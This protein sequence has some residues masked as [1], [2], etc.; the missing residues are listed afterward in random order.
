M[1]EVSY[2]KDDV[3]TQNIID[4]VEKSF[5]IMLRMSEA[6]HANFVACVLEIALKHV[7][8]FRLDVS[9]VSTLCINSLQQ[10]LGILLLE[11]YLVVSEQD[12]QWH[13]QKADSRP[14][15][16]KRLKIESLTKAKTDAENNED[17]ASLM[18]LE[19]AKLYRSISDYDS[20]KAIFNKTKLSSEHTRAG[21]EHE[22]NNDYYEA[23]KCYQEALNEL[24]ADETKRTHNRLGKLEEELWE[25]SLLRCCNELV[26]WR[27]MCE[28]STQTRKLNELFTDDAYSFECLF[29]YAFR[30][31][32][33]LVLQEDIDEQRKHEDLI[34]FLKSLTG[35]TKSFVENAYAYEL[36]L[37][38]MHQGD[39]NASRYF[40]YAA[41][42][43]YLTEWSSIN[44]NII[45][46]RMSK[47][48]SLQS[49]VEL[50]E[51]LNF[52]DQLH[53]Y[54]GGGGSGSSNGFNLFAKTN[55]LIDL[56][57]DAMPNAYSDPPATWDDVITNRCIYLE[58]I[59]EKHLN[60]AMASS[61]NSDLN[62]SSVSFLSVSNAKRRK[63]ADDDDNVEEK[64]L[65]RL[66][67]KIERTKILMKIRFAQALHI[68]GNFKL[69]MSKL[70]QTKSILKSQSS[71]LCDLQIAWMHCYLNAHLSRSRTALN[72]VEE[73]LSR[74]LGA[75][76]LQEICKYDEHNEIS[77]GKELYDE[78]KI[79][80]SKFATFL[81][82]SYQTL[83]SSDTLESYLNKLKKEEKK[84]NQ[85]VDYVGTKNLSDVKEV[86]FSSFFF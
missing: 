77:I 54:N 64:K 44:K 31:K 2:L 33:K 45:Q 53:V 78:Q 58:Y 27:S 42:Q 75:S 7:A 76:A 40:A 67:K 43:K 10:P 39:L 73:R 79:L 56:W 25:Q 28:W 36:A 37:L 14:P 32:L 80:H 12:P 74:F 17:E 18:W 22:S 30:S 21:F 61:S 52:V 83:S 82:D 38:N 68:Q 47:L 9:L 15:A 57:C 65:T 4:N 72:S 6:Y 85:L 55:T 11:E 81:I 66:V 71:D 35:E 84:Y 41:V 1:S 69:T 23:R 62:A 20:I 29:P 16:N 34:H 63:D 60:V 5:N 70:Q 26:D 8:L 24:A 51:F 46:S 86:I 59:E 3:E 48:Q 50:N 13:Q 49:I 19:L